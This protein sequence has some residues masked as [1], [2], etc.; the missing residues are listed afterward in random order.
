MGG[1]DV[2]SAGRR[3]CRKELK[4]VGGGQVEIAADQMNLTPLGK[5]AEIGI[6]DRGGEPVES[7][8]AVLL[9][10]SRAER[11]QTGLDMLGERPLRD[12]VVDEPAA[13]VAFLHAAFR[14][15]DHLRGEH[16]TDPHLLAKSQQ[17]DVDPGGVD[18]GEFGEVADPHHHL[19]GREPAA[20]VEIAAETGGESESDRFQ[21]GIDARFH[22]G[23]IESF[24]GLVEP[25]QCGRDVGDGHHLAAPVGRPLDVRGIHRE[26]ERCPGLYGGSHFLGIEA[27]DGDRVPVV[28][29]ASND[30]GHTAPAP[31][32]I[33]AEVDAVGTVGTHSPRL[34][35][36]RIVG[37]P[38]GM[39]DF[40]DDLDGVRAVVSKIAPLLAEV[41]IEPPQ[42]LWAPFDRG[43]AHLLHRVERAAD[44]ARKDHSVGS[45]RHLEPFG[46]PRRGHQGGNGDVHH[47]NGRLEADRGT[48]SRKHLP[49]RWF[50]E[51]AGHEVDALAGGGHGSRKCRKGSG[52]FLQ[53]ISPWKKSS[54]TIL[55]VG[56]GA[57]PFPFRPVARRFKTFSNRS[58]HRGAVLM[59][60]IL[61]T[62]FVIAMLGM[63]LVRAAEDGRLYEMR[64]YFAPPGKL[65]ALHARFRD[66]T[67]K[68]FAKHGMT[69]V[70]YFVPVGDNPERKLVY[71]L[72]YPDRQA[73]DA[74]WGAFVN[75]PEWK[76][77]YSASEKDGK[78]VEKA[79]ETFMTTTDYS[80]ALDIQN[81][82]KKRVFEL[83][84]YTSSPGNLGGLNARFR[85]HTLALFTRHGMRNL[86]YWNL[87]EG[88]PDADRKLIY[89]LSHDSVEAAKASFESFRKDPEWVTAREAS[90]KKAGGLLTEA[91]DGV[92]SEYLVPTD[93]SNWK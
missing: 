87:V 59:I 15:M 79:T 84:T 89:L 66:H 62:T 7:G 60:R 11:D 22:A 30:V 73:R 37:H 44:G 69:N 32:G 45:L 81:E 36:D 90:E 41:F 26:N 24:D 35:E 47:L 33:A 51:P 72:S 76:A 1:I 85:D 9:R 23:A 58:D 64:V 53:S 43:T 82:S 78:L 57:G 65:D 6:A 2:V 56:G 88:S 71:F 19:G 52:V 29:E 8:I 40:G 48:E 70:G 13:E 27:V 12:G 50:R 77:A 34:G 74:S 67:T 21:N 31:F 49:Q 86:I 25:L 4:W 17:E 14:P 55:H 83:R 28:D 20:D 38:R 16:R 92:L 18:V 5:D 63:T 80:P 54:Q 61:F 39:V 75:D 3:E 68:L 93:Y 42:V 46:D 10:L 91:K